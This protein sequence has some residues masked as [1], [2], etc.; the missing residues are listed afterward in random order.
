MISSVLNRPECCGSLTATAG[1]WTNLWR[2][3]T[4]A[5]RK[6]ESLLAPAMIA[7]TKRLSRTVRELETISTY[8]QFAARHPDMPSYHRERILSEIMK[9]SEDVR[10]ETLASL[11]AS[12]RQ[13]SRPQPGSS[14]VSRA[15]RAPALSGRRQLKQ[16]TS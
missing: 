9:C 13:A 11:E 12:R 4:T 15:A 5:A 8:A 1:V 10:R 7:E 16:K 3:I 6:S 14:T 2:T